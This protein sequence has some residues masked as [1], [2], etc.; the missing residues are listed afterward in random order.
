[1]YPTIFYVIA[2]LYCM[3]NVY[4]HHCSYGLTDNKVKALLLMDNAPAHPDKL[5][6]KD[7][8]IK[9]KFLPTN[10]TSLIQ[11]VD[12]EIIESA[13]ALQEP[14]PAAVPGSFGG[15]DG[16]GGLRGQ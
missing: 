6:S 4:A 15:W 10:T 13:D 16:R 11:P 14:L 8:Q 7:G 2:K 12:Q 9:V 1:M 3:S 5:I